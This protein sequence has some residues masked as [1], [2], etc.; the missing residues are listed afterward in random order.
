MPGSR[1]Q[2]AVIDEKAAQFRRLWRGE[3]PKGYNRQKKEA[4]RSKM[5]NA[6]QQSGLEF[7]NYN[8]RRLY[9]GEIE[10]FDPNEIRFGDKKLYLP[11]RRYLRDVQL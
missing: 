8:A 3:T 9:M 10:N 11:P 7:T 1:E 5:K 6:C 4:F 2:P